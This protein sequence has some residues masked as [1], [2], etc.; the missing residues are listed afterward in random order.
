MLER[1]RQLQLRQAAAR[2]RQRRFR[3]RQ[4][5]GVMP[6]VVEIDAA[7]IN[8]L[9]MAEWLAEADAGDKAA[10]ARAL[11]RMLAASSA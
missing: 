2:D 4:R 3:A 6:I 7:I 10:I 8:L 11:E 5:S 1:P 9:I